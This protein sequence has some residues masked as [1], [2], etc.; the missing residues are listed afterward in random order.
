MLYENVLRKASAQRAVYTAA[1]LC[2]RWRIW[3]LS[4]ESRAPPFGGIG[5]PVPS[6]RFLYVYVYVFVLSR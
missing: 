2:R 4:A 3:S 1:H 6:Y 5:K